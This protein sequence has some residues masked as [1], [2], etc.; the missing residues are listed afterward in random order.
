MRPGIAYWA[1]LCCYEIIVLLTDEPEGG[2]P[3]LRPWVMNF[4]RADVAP[5]RCV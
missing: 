2:I 3:A 4:D 5:D 1:D